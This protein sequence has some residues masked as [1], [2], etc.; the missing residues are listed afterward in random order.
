MLKDKK[1]RKADL[2]NALHCMLEDVRIGHEGSQSAT[3]VSM[4][5]KVNRALIEFVENF[6]E[7]RIE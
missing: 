4:S 6:R 2:C 3:R 1:G 7:L 5:A